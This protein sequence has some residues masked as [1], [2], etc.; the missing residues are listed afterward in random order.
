MKNQCP[1]LNIRR[2]T[3]SIAI[4]SI[5]ASSVGAL[6]APTYYPNSDN[7]LSEIKNST[8]STV[9]GDT[10]DPNTLYVM[11]PISGKATPSKFEAASA[12]M[13]YCQEMS[14][15][16]SYSRQL[17][18]QSTEAALKS[19][20]V[21][22]KASKAAEDW[23]EAESEVAILAQGEIIR[24]LRDNDTRIEAIELRLDGLYE[25]LNTCQNE[26]CDQINDEIV[27]LLDEKKLIVKSSNAIKQ[28]HKE[29]AKK[30]A[31]AKG[32]A[33]GAKKK[34]ELLSQEVTAAVT[35]LLTIKQQFN[36]AY[37]NLAKLEG[38]FVN[39]NYDTGWEANVLA[40]RSENPGFNI[41]MIP[42]EKAVMNANFVG[43][44]SDDAYLASLP[45]LLDYTVNGDKYLPWATNAEKTLSSFPGKIVANMRL[46]L[47]G[48]CVLAHPSKYDLEKGSTG[49]PVFGLAV[50]YEYPANF[51]MKVRFSYN[52][53][54]FYEIMQS[55]GSSGG[56]FTSRS[57][58][59]VSETNIS[60][61]AF[62]VAWEEE[63]P[64]NG[65][66]EVEKRKIEAEVKVE[67]I[68]RVLKQMARPDAS[69]Q[70]QMASAPAVPQHGALVIASGLQS[71][72]GFTSYYCA[73]GVWILRGLDSI[74][75]SSSSSSNFKSVNDHTAVEEWSRAMVRM[76][77]ATTVFSTN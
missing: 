10:N 48:A 70:V 35:R 61:D 59:N 58:T 1:V 9:L 77:P 51:R 37:A 26:A 31:K 16:Q 63:D 62:K 17:A 55:S 57:W 76:K 46:S 54:K 24:Q 2:Y 64:T 7:R 21:E 23:A 32:K 56:L 42:T 12:N 71:T 6:G 66:P 44:S 45:I 43:A 33:D 72:C 20:Q 8:N 69:S 19:A 49:F 11:P 5:L 27:Q 47:T 25:M 53:Y 60:H 29:E 3:Q 15:L 38:G 41:N 28:S 50:N 22:V 74:F 73:A 52:L 40:L 67:L 30:Y 4:V 36:S 39:V 18:K 13:G 75:G 34:Y 65:I 68:Q 14:D